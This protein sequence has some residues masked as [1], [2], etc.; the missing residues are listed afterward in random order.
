M[1]N[2]R[3]ATALHIL[4]LLEIKKGELL[5]SEFIAGSI[6][7]NPVVVRKEISNLRA[8]GFIESKEGKGGGYTLGKPGTQ[9]H[10]S[11]IYK[12]VNDSPLLGRSNNPNPD[13]PVG[14]QINV[15]LKDLFDVAEAA[16]LKQ[17]DKVTVK[18]FAKKFD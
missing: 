5:S 2:G 17:I 15:H 7:V 13:C 9:I 16:L 14:K 10:L 6:N 12:V 4:T 8:K 3:F 11:D 1:N 18:D